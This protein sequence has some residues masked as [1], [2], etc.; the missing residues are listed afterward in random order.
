M[1]N[2]NRKWLSI[3]LFILGL[4]FSLPIFAT[5]KAIIYVSLQGKNDDPG[6]RDEP[7]ASIEAG[8]AL[9]PTRGGEL[10]VAVGQYDGSVSLPNNVEIKGGYDQDFNQQSP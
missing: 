2:L 1:L 5:D 10:K 9:L 4:F 6:S 7:V 8:I 3:V